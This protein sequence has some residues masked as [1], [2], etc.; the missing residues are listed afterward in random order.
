MTPT[1][2]LH[3]PN[4]AVHYKDVINHDGIGLKFVMD[5][6]GPSDSRLLHP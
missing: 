1:T 2:Q 3:L 6:L 5:I 4:G